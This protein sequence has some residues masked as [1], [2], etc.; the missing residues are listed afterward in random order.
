MTLTSQLPLCRKLRKVK[1]HS[2]VPHQQEG[3]ATVC[4]SLFVV[5]HEADFLKPS[6]ALSSKPTLGHRV[7]GFFRSK[8]SSVSAICSPNYNLGH[9]SELDTEV[10]EH[11]RRDPVIADLT[12]KSSKSLDDGPVTALVKSVLRTTAMTALSTQTAGSD[13]VSKGPQQIVDGKPNGGVESGMTL[14]E[15]APVDKHEPS[16]PSSSTIVKSGPAV[17]DNPKVTNSWIAAELAAQERMEQNRNRRRKASAVTHR[18]RSLLRDSEEALQKNERPCAIEAANIEVQKQLE[19]DPS[20]PP[21]NVA[22]ASPSTP[23]PENIKRSQMVQDG[24]PASIMKI[25]DKYFNESTSTPSLHAYEAQIEELKGEHEDEII[26]LRRENENQLA[27]LRRKLLKSEAAKT[28]EQERAETATKESQRKEDKA[29]DLENEAATLRQRCGGLEEAIKSMRTKTQSKVKAK[30]KGKG[31]AAET[32]RQQNIDSGTQNTDRDIAL[33]QAISERDSFQQQNI[34]IRKSLDAA[35]AQLQKCQNDFADMQTLAEGK[36]HKLLCLREELER[37]PNAT[38]QTDELLKKQGEMHSLLVK[39]HNEVLG[40]NCELR[41]KLEDLEAKQKDEIDSLKTE[42]DTLQSRESLLIESHD[43]WQLACDQLIERLRSKMTVGDVEETTSSMWRLVNEDNK[44]LKAQVISLNSAL[45]LSNK[46]R[47]ESDDTQRQLRRVYETTAKENEDLWELKNH[48]Q[49]QIDAFQVQMDFHTP[50][51]TDI[52][53]DRDREIEE[54]SKQLQDSNKRHEEHIRAGA[55][56]GAL[57]LLQDKEDMANLQQQRLDA[58]RQELEDSS[59]QCY[60]QGEQ[61]NFNEGYKYDC[62]HELESWKVRAISAEQEV[63]ELRKQLD[64]GDEQLADPRKWEHWRLCSQWK[65]HGEII[66]KEYKAKEAKIEGIIGGLWQRMLDFEHQAQQNSLPDPDECLEEDRR[67]DIAKDFEQIFHYDPDCQFTCRTEGDQEPAAFEEPEASDSD[68]SD[69]SDGSD[70]D[71]ESGGSGIDKTPEVD[72]STWPATTES[73]DQGFVETIEDESEPIMM[74]QRGASASTH[75]EVYG[76]VPSVAPLFSLSPK[77]RQLQHEYSNP[78]E[79]SGREMD[80]QEDHD[81][82]LGDT[83]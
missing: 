19:L 75:Q 56:R 29:A 74:A 1:P 18:D 14:E 82:P 40:Q 72:Y 27:A 49:V 64:K 46:S 52:V 38:A 10:I 59:H 36:Q 23:S 51:C 26:Q 71:N 73:P 20:T 32:T 11:C 6:K 28:H 76:D 35:N 9:G 2:N 54:L 78:T 31:K 67:A 41:G 66:V 68:L 83:F 33:A 62:E 45:K 44:K 69:L 25:S 80:V 42:L 70:D 30:G 24:S 3:N 39:E 81:D 55:S 77:I 50:G 12:I 34:E 47:L 13:L 37:T 57:M 60:V 63:D 65:A 7:K 53:A 15:L 48:A 4:V 61:L 8:E 16:N 5:D 43:S 79:T 58:L 22:Q 21:R 17:T